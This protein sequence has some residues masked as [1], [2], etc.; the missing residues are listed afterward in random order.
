MAVG[1]SCFCSRYLCLFI[2][3]LLLNKIRPGYEEKGKTTFYRAMS[4]GTLFANVSS[5]LRLLFLNACVCKVHYFGFSSHRRVFLASRVK[6][7]PNS[8]SR[9][10]V[11]R[12]IVSGDIEL[13]PGSTNCS[14][15]NK[16]I[17]KNHRAL[18][19]N[20]RTLWCHMK[21]GQVKLKDYKRLQQMDQFNWIC[22]ACFLTAL[23]FAD[24]SILSSEGEQ[25]TAVD[26]TDIYKSLKDSRGNKNLKVGHINANG[27]INKL[28]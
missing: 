19:C 28:N 24:V 22:P 20:Q 6:Y 14:V 7:Y 27:I 25:E 15:C 2:L 11:M 13:N 4:F 18:S 10:E 16:V 12:V 5:D 1:C 3:L 17:A 26:H 9:F 21:C 8:D 23:P